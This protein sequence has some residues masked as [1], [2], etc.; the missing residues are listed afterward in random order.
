MNK[1]GKR[2]R[3]KPRDRLL[4]LENKLLVTVEGEGGEGEW[5][6]QVMGIKEYLL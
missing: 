6:K 2:E 1:G 5:V 3:N 4:T